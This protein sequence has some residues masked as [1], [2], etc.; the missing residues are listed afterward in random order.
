VSRRRTLLRGAAATAAALTCTAGFT[1]GAAAADSAVPESAERQS[2]EVKVTRWAHAIDLAPI[3]S[4]PAGSA[5]EIAKLRLR[6]ESGQAETYIVLHTYT[7]DQNREWA[8]I[9]VPGRP[10][11]RI[12][13]VLRDTLGDFFRTNLSIEVNRRTRRVT[14]RRAG[15]IIMRA[16]V[17]VGQPGTPTPA[18]HYMI[19]E[20]FTIPPGG[21]YGPRALG[22]SAYSAGLSGWPLG[23]II[24]F[25]GTTQPG[26]VPGAPSHG[27]I[28][29]HN[30]DVLR[31]YRI[32]KIG[33]PLWIR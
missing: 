27:C 3:R 16:P 18:G 2:D 6:M 32:V 10:N 17:G 9:R 25:H 19:R 13:W 4:R 22:T 20:R 28:R 14:L 33:T 12:G 26:L 29:M 21:V 5:K 30:D 23:G 7:D 15:K 31:F 11:G 24:G 1:G 8:R